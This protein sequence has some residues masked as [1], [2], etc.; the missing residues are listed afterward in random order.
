[1]ETKQASIHELRRLVQESCR[2][3][4][5]LTTRLEKAALLMLLRPI[6]PWG[7]ITTK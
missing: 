7:T 2:N 1:M 5:H 6:V 3:N 4:P